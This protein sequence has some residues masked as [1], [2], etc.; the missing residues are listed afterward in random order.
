[1]FTRLGR[2]SR[3]SENV[4][5]IVIILTE[6]TTDIDKSFTIISMM[7]SMNVKFSNEKNKNEGFLV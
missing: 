6:Y 7:L 1:M 5:H 4:Q 2:D 3:V